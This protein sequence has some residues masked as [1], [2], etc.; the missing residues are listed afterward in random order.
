MVKAKVNWHTTSAKI[1]QKDVVLE[2][3]NRYLKSIGL[4]NETVKLYM[5]RLNAFLDHAKQDEPPIEVANDYRD[6]LIDSNFSRTHIN[7][8]CFAINKFYKMNNIEWN[9]TFLK[10]NE[11]VP[12]YFA[13]VI[14]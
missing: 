2:R 14:G 9:F 8:T 1:F 4:R 12:Y 5:G 6:M 3:F 11:G 7:N 13:S 10:P